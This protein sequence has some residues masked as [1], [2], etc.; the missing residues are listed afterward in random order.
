MEKNNRKNK[1]KNILSTG[2]LN[3]QSSIQ[4]ILKKILILS[5]KILFKNMM[6]LFY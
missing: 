1:M 4:V 6:L 2:G 3:Q 5:K